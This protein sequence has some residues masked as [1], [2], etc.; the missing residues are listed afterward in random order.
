[1]KVG[2]SEPD[3]VGV[4][5]GVGVVV[6]GVPVTVGLGVQVRVCVGVRV[7]VGVG[8]GVS[9]QVWVNVADNVFVGGRGEGVSVG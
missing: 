2:V 5:E 4:T 1:M 7:I 8:D 6:G 3:S 9:G